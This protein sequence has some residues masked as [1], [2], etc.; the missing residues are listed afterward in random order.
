[1]QDSLIIKSRKVSLIRIIGVTA[2]VCLIYFSFILYLMNALEKR[3][4][5][6]KLTSFRNAVI[7][8]EQMYNRYPE[9]YEEL[10]RLTGMIGDLDINKYRW[11][12]G[13]D[14]EPPQLIFVKDGSN[15]DEIIK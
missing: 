15:S 10:D 8:F 6:G 2:I 7:Y 3:I 14:G 12:D 9:S 4:S 1:M 13:I 5:L 11:I